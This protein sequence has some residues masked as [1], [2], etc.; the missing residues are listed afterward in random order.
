MRK[1]THTRTCAHTETLPPPHKYTSH[2]HTHTRTHTLTHTNFLHTH[3]SRTEIRTHL[4]RC[5]AWKMG[6]LKSSRAVILFYSIQN[7]IIKLILFSLKDG[8]VEILHLPWKIS[9]QIPPLSR[10]FFEI[11]KSGDIC[12]W[13]LSSFGFRERRKKN[14]L[15]FF[16]GEQWNGFFSRAATRK[17]GLLWERWF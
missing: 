7:K 2:T 3:T 15:W 16:F 13:K 6:P 14:E 10:I 5:P 4:V 12:F 8:T 9:K 17:M 1:H 11:L